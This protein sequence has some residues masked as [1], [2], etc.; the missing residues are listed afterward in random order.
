MV[1]IDARLARVLLRRRGA[2]FHDGDPEGVILKQ[3][4]EKVI[5]GLFGNKGSPRPLFRDGLHT[6]RIGLQTAAIVPDAFV[7]RGISDRIDYAVGFQL[8]NPVLTQA[9]NSVLVEN[10]AEEPITIR[11]PSFVK[12]REITEQVI[13]RLEFLHLRKGCGGSCLH[14][15]R[16]INLPLSFSRPALEWAPTCAVLV[17][18]RSFVHQSVPFQEINSS[19]DGLR[20]R[21]HAPRRHLERYYLV[22]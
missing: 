2:I 5:D 15:R 14:L 11:L 1:G 20:E 22:I 7:R 4:R 3:T 17:P 12:R 16:H 8:I 19:Q 6:E 9:S 21:R 10:V 18:M 13:V